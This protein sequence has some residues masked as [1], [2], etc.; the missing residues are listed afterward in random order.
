[1]PNEIVQCP[2]TDTT[3]S[4]NLRWCN[5]VTQHANQDCTIFSSTSEVK[6]RFRWRTMPSAGISPGVPTLQPVYIRPSVSVAR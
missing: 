3:T 2:Q 4:Q 6:I 5:R 1:M